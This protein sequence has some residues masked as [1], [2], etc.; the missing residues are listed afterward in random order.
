MVFLY[1][2]QWSRA[3][4]SRF[5]AN[6]AQLGGVRPVAF[7]DGPEAGVRGLEFRTGAG[8]AFTVLPD[9]GMD[10]GLTEIDGV[11][12][13]FL[14]A[15]GYAH[16]AYF[17]PAGLGWLRTFP[18]GLFVTCG[19]DAAGAPSE[20]A[21]V[22]FGLH[23]RASALPAR[24]VAFDADWEG[25]EYVLRARGK[26]RQVAM[27]GEWLQLTREITARL[28]Q[29]RFAIR[30]T[31]ENLGSRTEPHML[32]YHFNVGYPLLDAGA[33]FLVRSVR[34]EGIDERSRAAADSYGRV[35]GPSPDFEEE[36]IQHDVAPGPDGMVTAAVRNSALMGG[37]GLALT[38]RYRKDQLPNLVQWRNFRERAYVMGIE[39]ANC[40]IRGRAT[41][42]ERGALQE[43]APG[44]RR[45]YHLEVEALTDPAAIAALSA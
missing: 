40:D 44:E 38:I 25:D 1:G 45:E 7:Q 37:R 35:A 6:M 29:N 41:S 33:E 24:G 21:G 43:L 16:P 36:V 34:A 2:R 18:G 12:L 13:S 15:V 22:P 5:V 30:D 19:L 42:R 23:G 28:G 32:V 8:L 31:V 4:L 10:V 17:E 11:P 20:D 39:P 14:T 3:E 27:H 26:M 9:R